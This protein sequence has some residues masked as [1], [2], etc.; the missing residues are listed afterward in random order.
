V[1]YDDATTEPALCR[2]ERLLVFL[3]ARF[4]A[5]LLHA[6]D[7]Q[8]SRR[9]LC[10]SYLLSCVRRVFATYHHVCAR[11]AI[12]GY[13]SPRPRLSLSLSLTFPEL[14]FASF[15]RNGD[16]ARFVGESKPCRSTVCC[17]ESYCN[18]YVCPR[19]RSDTPTF[20]SVTEHLSSFTLLLKVC[21]FPFSVQRH[22]NSVHPVISAFGCFRL[23]P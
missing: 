1:I 9:L 22:F 23:I 8:H 10:S 17:Q 15:C 6:C 7:E 12:I 13:Q 2:N 21:L 20:F 3:P 11:N 4:D 14:G 16:T 5:S 19:F 18:V